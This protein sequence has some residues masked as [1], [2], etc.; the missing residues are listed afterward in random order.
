MNLYERYKNRV[1]VEDLRGLMNVKPPLTI[2]V[3]TLKISKE[4]LFQ[5][6]TNKGFTITDHPVHDQALIVLKEPF[7]VGATTEYLAGFYLLQDA[8][9][10][11]AV[12]ELGLKP[13]ELVLDLTA[14]P[15]AKTTHI[16]ELLDNTGVVVAVDSDKKRLKSVKFN[17]ERMGCENIIALNIKGQ[18][19]AELG[20]VFDK[21]LLD[22]PCSAEGTLH[23]NPEVLKKETHYKRIIKEQLSLIETAIRVLKPGGTL[24]YSTCAIN[25]DENEGVVNHALNQGLKLLKPLTKAGIPGIGLK[26]TRRFYPH[27]DNTQGFFIARMVKG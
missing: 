17:C 19:V 13:G 12:S 16:C 21:V 1:P 25:P 27:R 18:E 7:S 14:A 10:M 9:S 23:K 3:N 26:K 22:A 15:G 2:R 5:V 4:D 6:L 24:V 11:I 8:A 20:L